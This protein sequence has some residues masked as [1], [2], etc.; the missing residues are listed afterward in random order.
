[1]CIRDRVEDITDRLRAE[2]ELRESRERLAHVT[3]LQTVSEMAAGIAHEINQPLTAISVYAEASRRLVLAGEIDSGELL[4]ALE[5][6]GRQARR[7]GEV[8]RRLKGLVRRRESTRIL[9]DLNELT[10]EIVKLAEIDAR[11]HEAV[12]RMD[13]GP[14]L[15]R[16]VV[17]PVQIQ[18]VVL[19]LV[20]NGMEAMEKTPPDERVITLRTRATA[21]GSIEISVED[22]GSG[23]SREAERNLFR[24][25]FT[26]KPSGTGMGLAISRTIL[27]SHGGRLW[28][29]RNA[30]RGTTFRLAVPV[31]GEEKSDE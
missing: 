29:T 4:E 7:A 1:M 16:T 14:N 23:V 3:R 17:D 2:R 28:F 31:I 5:K 18:Q 12:I 8:V 22:R 10:R 30:G 15:P 25:F 21:A 9:A 20:L 26:T 11:M 27:E 24:T 6:V 13:L 19:N